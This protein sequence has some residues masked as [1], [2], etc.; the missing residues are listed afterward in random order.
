MF[1]PRYFA[2]TYFGPRYW[3]PDF[4]QVEIPRPGGGGTGPGVGPGAQRSPRP[5]VRDEPL[6]L[7]QALQ[8]D[9]DLIILIKAF[10]E[11]IQWH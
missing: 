7:Q 9:E 3:P 2:P 8:E 10:A 5:S 1:A 6:F 4:I 11:V